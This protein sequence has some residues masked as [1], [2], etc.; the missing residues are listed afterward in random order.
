MRLLRH[1]HPTS[2][3]AIA[4]WHLRSRATLTWIYPPAL[5]AETMRIVGLCDFSLDVLPYEYP[6]ELTPPKA[7]VRICADGGLGTVAFLENL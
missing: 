2:S 5:L 7:V 1:P 6:L 4:E 3:L